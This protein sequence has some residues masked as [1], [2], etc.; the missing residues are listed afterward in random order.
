MTGPLKVVTWPRLSKLFRI[1]AWAAGSLLGL[2]TFFMLLRD[3]PLAPLRPEM[4]TSGPGPVL[5]AAGIG[6]LLV[7]PFFRAA[8]LFVEGRDRKVHVILAAS[9]IMMSCAYVVALL[10]AW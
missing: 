4:V 7:L 10:F 9:A 5:L 6:V 2:G 8:T 1:G 3:K